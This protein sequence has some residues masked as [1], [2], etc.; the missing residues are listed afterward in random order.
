M[1]QRN[2]S[3]STSPKQGRLTGVESNGDAV[4][5]SGNRGVLIERESRGNWTAVIDEGP[6]SNG[7]NLN[8]LSITDD[9]ERVW[10]AGDSGALGYY[11]RG[12]EEVVSHH[13]PGDYT[14]GFVTVEVSGRSGSEHVFFANNSGSSFQVR[15]DGESA[16]SSHQ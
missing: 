10:Y 2:W 7:N 14:S 9:G 12:A 8:D 5:A 4:F 3:R 6:R 16:E 11:D 1:R 15:A 13:A